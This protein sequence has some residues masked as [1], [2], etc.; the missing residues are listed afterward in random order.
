MRREQIQ[1]IRRAV[2]PRFIRSAIMDLSIYDRLA[3]SDGIQDAAVTVCRTMQ[4][5]GLKSS[6][7]TF[8][9]DDETFRTVP[10]MNKWD[11]WQ[12]KDGWCEVAGEPGHRIADY[13]A[14]PICVL[15]NS[16][17]C[18]CR[19]KPVEVILMDKGSDEENYKDVDFTG[20]IIFIKEQTGHYFNTPAYTSWA[21]GKRGAIGHILSAV[22]TAENVRGTWNQYD[23]IAWSRAYKNAFAFGITPR[24][25][26]RL[27]KLY[28]EKQEK[29]EK[30][31]V[32]C[33]VNATT[34]GRREMSNVDTVIEGSTDEEVIMYAH[35]CHPRP[36]ANDNLS[37]CSAVMSAMYALNDLISRGILPPPKRTIRGII[38]P[39]MIGSAAEICRRDRKYK[40]R[41]AINMD[42][43]GAQQGPVGVGP[44][45]LCDAPRSTPNFA[46]DVASLCM[47]EVKK[48]VR[49]FG[50]E[51][52]CV[53]NMAET[54]YSPGSDHD[55]WNDGEFNTPCPCLGQ[56]PDRYYHSSS[57]DIS[58]IDPALIARSAAIS[59][60]YAYILATLE[61][62]DLP[63][64]MSKG[65]ENMVRTVI[66]HPFDGDMD[67]YGCTMHHIRDYYLACC[68]QYP[69]FFDD[70]EQKRKVCELVSAQK[71]RIREIFSNIVDSVAGQHIELDDY[72]CDG[73]ELDAKY[74]FVPK[75]NFIGRL[76]SLERISGRTENGE[77]LIREFRE[78]WDISFER[79]DYLSLFYSNGERTFAECITRSMIDRNIKDRETMV[80]AVYDFFGLLIKLG[81]VS[82]VRQ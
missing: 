51:W 49:N 16:V 39:E 28:Y 2:N 56:W 67:Q 78:K 59:A 69:T 33:Y 77:E 62:D 9:A 20:K 3:A 8:H 72:P 13:N 55:I 35:L 4:K 6:L 34:E 25:G 26:D 80:E 41:A 31:E 40:T 38:G 36:S 18:D 68:D 11:Y 71:K 47:E 14:D 24:E 46:N 75:K 48:D 30:L 63:M 70:E 64:I 21:I 5:L 65:C 23:T 10:S 50:N 82:V 74:Q 19:N 58:T 60:A 81:A 53:H 57:D 44:V 22:A 7:F 61:P 66:R 12:C 52:L 27:A 17:S 37:G 15:W 45:F 43:V 42:M 54:T 79:C 1:T 73:R 29:G 32:F 76:F